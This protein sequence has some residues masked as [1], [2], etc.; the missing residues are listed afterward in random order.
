MELARRDGGYKAPKIC[1]VL[2]DA[3]SPD[4]RFQLLVEDLEPVHDI[5]WQ[6]S[7]R[8]SE[9]QYLRT[10]S[11]V[12]LEMVLQ[13]AATPST[14]E[15]RRLALVLAHDGL[16]LKRPYLSAAT[17]VVPSGAEPPY[18]DMHHHG[19][20][21]ILR[22]G[23]LLLEVHCWRPIE[24]YYRQDVDSLNGRETPLTELSVAR[25]V[26]SSE[27]MSQNCLP[28]YTN[29]L[30]ACLHPPWTASGSKISLNNAETQKG[31]YEDVVLALKSEVDVVDA[32][33]G[34]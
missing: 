25:R 33:L 18:R 16:D 34:K 20:P 28:T 13:T 21:G 32:C 1:D 5:Y 4:Q 8:P 11:E 10:K 30:D 17:H 9:V 27:S 12:S 6:L 26:L 31:I 22:L 14:I 2:R 15:R 3:Y 19:N 7:R 24:S 23:I 29:A